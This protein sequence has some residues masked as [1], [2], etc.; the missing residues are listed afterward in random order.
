MTSLTWRPDLD[1]MLT[2]DVRALVDAATEAD[3]TAPVGEQVILG[4]RPGSPA[5][6]LLAHD[7]PRLV[8]YAQLDPGSNG[9]DE[10]DGSDEARAELAVHPRARRRG[11][12]AALVGAL[13]AQVGAG[14]A[15]RVWAHG[16]HPGA[17]ALA[18]RLGFG[19][20]RELWQLHRSLAEPLPPVGFPDGVRLRAFVV[21]RDEPEFL[22]VNNAAFAWHPEQGG[23]GTEQVTEREEEPWFDPAGL[24]LATEGAEGSP[25]DPERLLGF[26]WTK[27]H[28]AA[29]GQPAIGEVYVLG[30]DP[31]A[32]GRGLG[33]AL[34]L[35][36]LEH[37]RERGL[38]A[39]ML[40]VESDN[41]SAVRVYEKLGFTRWH[42]DVAFRHPPP[43]SD[44]PSG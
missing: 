20:A 15:L 38:D 2:A 39:V 10:S 43:P 33:G 6:H 27:V 4:L 44:P 1:E 14:R 36:G 17:A 12:G 32:H 22:R 34:T 31:A 5:R 41:G 28:P 11:V 29:A 25:D 30:V 26:H 3:G 8:G 19:T 35:A 9:S 37:L 7:G 23:W 16:E 18:D 40:Y 13:L 42:T 21:G 24:L